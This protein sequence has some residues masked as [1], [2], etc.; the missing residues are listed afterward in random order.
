MTVQIVHT[1]AEVSFDTLHDIT[2]VLM[3]AIHKAFEGQVIDAAALSA[4]FILNGLAVM[5]D[6]QMDHPKERVLDF[7]RDVDMASIHHFT[8]TRN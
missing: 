3:G 8:Q 2:D 6:A 1:G 5:K 4:A 7:V